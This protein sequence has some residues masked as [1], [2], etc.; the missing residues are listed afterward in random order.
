MAEDSAATAIDVLANDS[1]APDTGETLTITGVTQPA[2]GT[3]VI[4]GGGSGL[5]FQPASP[6]FAGTTT[7]TYTV[8]DGNG[9]TDTATVTMTVTNVN[10]P[11][12]AVDDTFGRRGG[13][14]RDGG[15]GAGE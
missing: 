15:P 1:T 5:T 6:D 3:V 11:P 7:F 2:G 14:G 8:S 9:G 4:T 10:D 12:V 13:R